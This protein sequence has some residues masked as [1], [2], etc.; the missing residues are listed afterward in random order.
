M[1]SKTM[2]KATKE[3]SL[4]ETYKKVIRGYAFFFAGVFLVLFAFSQSYAV[5][6]T[7]L[8]CIILLVLK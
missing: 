5:Q 7:F 3:N 2:Q 4:V 8:S 6:W 1:K